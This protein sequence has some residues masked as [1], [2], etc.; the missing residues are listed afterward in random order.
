MDEQLAIQNYF[1]KL[2]KIPSMIPKPSFLKIEDN[3]V[4]FTEETISEV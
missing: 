2:D 4:K 3:W 1:E